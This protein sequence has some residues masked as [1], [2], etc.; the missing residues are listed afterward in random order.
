MKNLNKSVFCFIL[1]LTTIVLFQK[2]SFALTYPYSAIYSGSQ[3][4]PP[5]VTP[6]TATISGTYDNVT[7]IITVSVVFS[8]LL[9]NTT[10]AHFHAPAPPGVNASVTVPFAGF[11]TGVQ[12]GTYINFTFVLTPTQEGQFLSNLFYANIHTNLFGGGELRAQI[13]PDN[14]LPVELAA[15]TSIINRNNVTLN[16]STVSETN[17]KGFE[18]ERAKLNVDW[19]KV[20]YVNGNGN[21]TIQSNYT[22]TDRNVE[23]GGYFYR[24]KQIDY[25]GSFKYYN[26]SNEV[27]I[28]I[29]SS[30]NMSQNY[31]N[32]FNPSTKVDFDL[33]F[34]GKVSLVLFDMSGKTIGTLVNEFKPAGYY[35]VHFDASGLSSGMYLYRISAGN[36][37]VTKKMMLVK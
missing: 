37:E 18:I 29:P 33:P 15:F 22:F 28:G 6:A 10:A 30:Y 31:P 20:G 9:G 3:E 36:F 32:P 2:S 25:N 4:V 11:P 23:K 7:K 17:N 24:L 35:S 14:P 16:W 8:G 21:S 26:L 34:D 5:V 12:S 27:N 19:S 13:V 1:I